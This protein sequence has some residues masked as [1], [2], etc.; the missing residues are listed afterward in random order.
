MDAELDRRINFGAANLI[1][2]QIPK[3]G[4][5]ISGIITLSDMIMT[6]DILAFGWQDIGRFLPAVGTV[7]TVSDLEKLRNYEVTFRGQGC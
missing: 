3:A 6:G 2:D 5:A 1:A 4:I 7:M